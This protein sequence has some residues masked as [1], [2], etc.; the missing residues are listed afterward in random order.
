MLK[1]WIEKA[2]KQTLKVENANQRY[3]TQKMRSQFK[4]G[5]DR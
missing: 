4:A 5:C 3:K 1:K 2:A